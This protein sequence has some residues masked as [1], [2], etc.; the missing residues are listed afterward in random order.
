MAQG[1]GETRDPEGAPRRRSDRLLDAAE[2][3]LWIALLVL[4]ILIGL[5]VLREWAGPK[6]RQAPESLVE[7]EDLPVVGRSRD[8]SFWLQPTKDFAGGGW[9]KDAH[10]FAVTDRIGD[11]IELGLPERKPGRY[12]LE[13]FAT[14]AGD[15]G[16][17]AASVDGQR[18]DGDID[19]WSGE[20]VVPTGRIDLGS[21]ELKGKGDVLRLEVIGANRK[22]SPPFYQFGV[23]GIRLVP[24]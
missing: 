10:M 6:P 19:L 2:V 14:R 16:V 17:L 23:D 22:A 12:R 3:V 7:A 24:E 1:G 13:I 15:Y 11:W 9:S 18:A 20:G 21:V 4:G 5:T 8:F